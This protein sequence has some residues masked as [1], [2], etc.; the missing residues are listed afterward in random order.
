MHYESTIKRRGSFN[1]NVYEAYHKPLKYL[2]NNG[3]M[4][5]FYMI[6]ILASVV[7]TTLPMLLS[8]FVKNELQVGGKEFS[9]M[10]FT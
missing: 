9:N 3:K 1:F 10:L 6:Q 8:M 7:F 4:A 5:V 2:T